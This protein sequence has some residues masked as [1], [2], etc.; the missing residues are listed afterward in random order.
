MSD[1]KYS[2][3]LTFLLTSHEEQTQLARW[4]F[5][6][7]S[8]MLKFVEE[9]LLFFNFF[10]NR[11]KRG[12]RDVHIDYAMFSSLS[13]CIKCAHQILN[14]KYFFVNVFYRHGT[15]LPALVKKERV[16]PAVIILSEGF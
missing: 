7:V 14:F 13:F 12:R 8:L 11:F 6:V 5:V 2:E 3:I 4:R 9:M 15:K 1:G 16:M 10:K